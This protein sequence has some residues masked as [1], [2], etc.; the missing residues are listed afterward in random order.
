VLIDTTTLE[1]N[2]VMLRIY[3]SLSNDTSKCVLEKLSHMDTRKQVQGNLLP[4]CS[5]QNTGSKVNI[6]YRRI[7]EI[8][9]AISIYVYITSI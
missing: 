4:Y 7:Y 3:F 9:T 6:H 8:D 1:S 2:L 5:K